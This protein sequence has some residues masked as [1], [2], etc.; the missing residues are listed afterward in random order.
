MDKSLY[1]NRT[2]SFCAVISSEKSELTRSIQRNSNYLPLIS[3][4]ILT[5][6]QDQQKK[7][8][9]PLPPTHDVWHHNPVYQD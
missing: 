6:Q 1:I 2:F 3:H 9:F 4:H 8:H 5:T 7:N